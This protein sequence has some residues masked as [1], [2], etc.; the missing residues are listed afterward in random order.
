MDSIVIDIE[1]IGASDCESYLESVT[2]PA[3]YKDEAKIA[4]YCAEKRASQIE[5]A[6]LEADLCEVVAVGYRLFNRASEMCAMVHTRDEWGEGALLEL[7]WD[8]VMA[9]GH[10]LP[11]EPLQIIGFNCLGFDL[12]VLIRRSQLLGVRYPHISL[13]R[14]RTPHIDL[15]QKLTF[16]G[17]LTMRSLAFY[18]RRFGIPHDDKITGADIARLVAE[19]NWA[20]VAAHCRADVEGAAALAQK[21]GYLP[22]VRAEE[23]V[24]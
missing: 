13:D 18:L 1:T 6:G 10:V 24:L 21:L 16:N 12:P 22:A 8:V 9:R 19:G 4:A 5:R 23:M 3:N 11:V 2:A 7:L 14:Y 17:A 15:L 20:A